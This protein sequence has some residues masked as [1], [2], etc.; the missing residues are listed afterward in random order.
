M[1]RSRYRFVNFVGGRIMQAREV[2]ALQDIAHG[3][4]IDD[5]A[6]PVTFDLSAIYAEGATFNITPV[7]TPSTTTVTLTKTDNAKPMLVFVR[8]RWEI[9]ASAEAPAL[10]LT[11]QQTKVFLNW[12]LVKRDAIADVTLIDTTTQEAT[13]EMGELVLAVSATSDTGAVDGT[14]FEKNLAD[15]VLF[16]FT[17]GGNTM[18]LNAK[19]NV[20]TQA[21]ASPSTAGL[22]KT[23]T[24]NPVVPSTND[25]RMSDDRAPTNGSVTDAKVHTP[26]SGADTTGIGTDKIVH[27]P[28]NA[29]LSTVVQGLVSTDAALDAR[30]DAHE[31]EHL[32]LGITHP[33]P[34]ASEVG[35]T[36]ASHA[37]LGLEAGHGLTTSKNTSGFAVTRDKNVAPTAVDPAFEVKD[38]DGALA[39]LTHDGDVYSRLAAAF[40]APVIAGLPSG[41]LGLL[42]KVAEVLAG[43]AT[44]KG[45]GTRSA[46]NPHGLTL[47]DLGWTDP[48]D[49]PPISLQPAYDYTDD[50]I[51]DLKAYVDLANQINVSWVETNVGWMKVSFGATPRVELAF[52][53]GV[54]AHGAYLQA[55]AGFSYVFATA[56]MG[57]VICE[58]DED[59]PAYFDYRMT[60]SNQVVAHEHSNK[61]GDHYGEANILAFAWRVV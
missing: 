41:A 59:D 26:S 15:I 49:P 13:A 43:H 19:D 47:V 40:S 57:H 53:L 7:I 54:L 6:A 39:K 1:D 46:N 27:H 32:G 29:L 30:Q 23:T 55:L 33:F 50:A 11:T 17:H 21:L 31:G 16:E 4:D 35:A 28:D 34:T 8:G 22:V 44:A 10:T 5:K 52:G 18:T 60:G 3:V 14:E 24:T 2:N 45:A 37:A 25:A 20:Q 51:A 36:P 38:Q 12:A 9:L 61:K 48:D 42:S 56:S 58:Y